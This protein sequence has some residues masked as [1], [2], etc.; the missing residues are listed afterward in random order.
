DLIVGL[1]D[2]VDRGPNSRGVIDL[3]R[4]LAERCQVVALRGNHEVMMLESLRGPS[5][6]GA[7]RKASDD[8]EKIWRQCGG[9]AALASYGG[10]LSDVPDDHRQFLE[11]LQPYYETDTHI[12]VHACYAPHRPMHKQSVDALYWTSLRDIVPPPHTSGKTVVVGHTPQKTGRPF[13]G[14]HIK[15]IDTF[16]WKSGWLTGY[17]VHAGTLW[18]VD[19]DGWFNGQTVVWSPVIT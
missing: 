13:D 9:T 15:G 14:G 16:C 19:K 8:I 6:S 4:Q 3:V 11:Q 2:Y 7:D 18:Q 12:F 17:D 10:R 1:G 5:R